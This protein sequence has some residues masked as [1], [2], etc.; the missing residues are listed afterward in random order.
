MAFFVYN[1]RDGRA[2]GP[3]ETAQSFTA[4]EKR[5]V[6]IEMEIDFSTDYLP[7][8]KLSED[9]LSLV[10]P[11]AGKTI[12]EQKQAVAA[13]FEV[14]EL[15]SVKEIKKQF[16]RSIAKEKLEDI[17]WKLDK[18]KDLDRVNGNNN[19][20]TAYYNE[21]NAI[22]IANNAHEDALDALTDLQAVKDFNPGDF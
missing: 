10:N 4:D 22:R 16:I 5:D 14:E 13:E 11:H 7:C 8:F 2:V 18:A 19:A 3:Y 6:V 1:R 15:A 20:L 9:G 17:E 12:E 21:R